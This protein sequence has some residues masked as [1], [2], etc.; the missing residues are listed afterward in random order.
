MM[1]SITNVDFF[2]SAR[3]R[4]SRAAVAST[5]TVLILSMS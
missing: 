4:P 2:W 3:L 5:E 1:N